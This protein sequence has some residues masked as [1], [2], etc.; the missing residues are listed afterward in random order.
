[1]NKDGYAIKVFLAAVIALTFVLVVGWLTY[2]FGTEKDATYTIGALTVLTTEIV[3]RIFGIFRTNGESG[4]K[5]LP[6]DST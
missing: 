3:R 6:S 1:M 2:H 4:A 5:V